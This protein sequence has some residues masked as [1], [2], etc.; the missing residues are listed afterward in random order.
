MMFFGELLE[1]EGL[2]AKAADAAET[3]LGKEVKE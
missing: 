3:E 2:E 1:S